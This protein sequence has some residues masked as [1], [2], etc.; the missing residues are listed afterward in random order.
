MTIFRPLGLLGGLV[1][2]LS[3]SASLSAQE[4]P[5][6]LSHYQ[7]LARE[8]I[9]GERARSLVDFMDPSYRV[10]GNAPFDA[11]IHRV[12][13]ILR[14]AGY[15]EEGKGSGALTYRIEE[16]PL[17]RPTWE[18]VRAS[19][20][21]VGAPAPLMTLDTNINLVAANSHSTP[22][23]GVEAEVVYVGRGAPEDFEGRDVEGKIVM[24]E[25]RVSQL[26]SRA[27]GEG[28]ALGVLAYRISAYNRPEVNR[29]VA[30][31][32]S[33]PYDSTAASWGLLLSGNARDAILGAMEEGPVRLKVEVDTRIYPSKELTLV[34]EVQGEVQPEE[35]FVFSAHVQESGA[36]DNATG[37]AS[38][39]EIAGAL[40]Q[41][42]NTGVLKP[43][44]SITM[45]WG[46][47][48][49]STRRY[50]SQDS[51]RAEGVV[52]GLSLD[53]VGE[54]TEK[55][56]G[57][58]LIEKMPDPSAVW[59]RGEDKHTEWGGRPLSPDQL[60]P[61]YLND[62]ILRRCLD[63]ASDS[64]WVVRTNP[65]EGGSDH[66][67]FLR[68]G[69]AGILL[70]HFTDQHYHTDGDRLEMVSAET[71]WN[72]SVSAA[73]SAMT[74]VTVDAEMAEY[75]VQEVEAAAL[76]RL[77]VEAGLSLEA[78]AQGG[79]PVDERVILD[80]WTEWYLG[81]LDAMVELEAGGASASTL[82]AIDGARARV[83]VVGDSYRESITLGPASSGD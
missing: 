39:A 43:H 25:G 47:E 38:L 57:T 20:S 2:L 70:W 51:I 69:T 13:E 26:F 53:M 63:Q 16:Y 78:V 1:F 44:R 82:A 72:V 83:R 18:P 76:A 58:F 81:A 32:S 68:A 8:S 36:N 59:T 52:W 28:G 33:I 40:A 80:S 9:S 37:V 55:T 27:V 23:G 75:L 49:S 48:I 61:H 73:V 66:V 7:R 29:D 14:E 67:P 46:D 3:G 45:I 30:P 56:G 4:A 10:P 22:A 6:L 34:A 60:T 31:M 54:D 50:L 65:Y 42:V 41:G 79:D 11:A 24:G 15:V 12:A 35:R 71:L 62:F 21:I 5:P 77:A 64:D 74:L 19:L 17:S